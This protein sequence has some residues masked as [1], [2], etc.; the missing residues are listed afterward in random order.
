[1]PRAITA[2]EA[3]GIASSVNARLEA[4][5]PTYVKRKSAAAKHVPRGGLL[6][7]TDLGFVA[8]AVVYLE[9]QEHTT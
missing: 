4:V 7:E 1:M 2:R 6:V 5:T 8:L 9:T 3:I